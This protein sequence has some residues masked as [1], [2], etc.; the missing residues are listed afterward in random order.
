MGKGMSRGHDYSSPILP[1]E[2]VD[3]GHFSGIEALWFA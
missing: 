3:R 1:A 2:G